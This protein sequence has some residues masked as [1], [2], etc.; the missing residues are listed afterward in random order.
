MTILTSLNT[1]EKSQDFVES[2]AVRM[3]SG[4][5][6]CYLVYLLYTVTVVTA[7]VVLYLFGN[8]VVICGFMILMVLLLASLYPLVKFIMKAEDHDLVWDSDGL[9][10]VRKTDVTVQEYG[11]YGSDLDQSFKATPVNSNYFLS[12][13][14]I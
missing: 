8:A 6:A 4:S 1:N 14:F 11:N 5:T 3:I 10:W 2:D 12:Y 9:H 13:A 7:S